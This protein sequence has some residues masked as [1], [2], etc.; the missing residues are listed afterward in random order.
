M[1]L[2]ISLVAIVLAF[3]P[4]RMLLRTQYSLIKTWNDLLRTEDN[5]DKSRALGADIP[6]TGTR[7]VAA[8]HL[9]QLERG[10]PLLKILAFDWIKKVEPR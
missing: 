9:R 10:L 3:A 6:E 5:F 1:T 7:K 8:K 4:F 2:A